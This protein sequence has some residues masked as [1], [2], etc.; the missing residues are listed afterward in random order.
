MRC[1]VPVKIK[2]SPTGTM[3]FSPLFAVFVEPLQAHL[4]SSAHD[5]YTAFFL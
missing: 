2:R 1:N 5:L 3:L 4:A